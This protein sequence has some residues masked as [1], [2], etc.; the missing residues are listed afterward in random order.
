MPL[1]V[2]RIS[3]N[4]IHQLP[5]EITEKSRVKDVKDEVREKLAP[6]FPNGCKLKFNGRVLKSRH[7]LKHYGITANDKLEMDDTKDWSSS[8]SASNSED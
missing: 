1:R 5:A 4:A 6:K 8:S 7:S 2:H 3:D